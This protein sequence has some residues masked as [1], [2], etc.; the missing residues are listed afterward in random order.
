MQVA[1]RS[2][3]T[4]PR[5]IHRPWV[6]VYLSNT[7]LRWTHRANLLQNITLH[8]VVLSFDRY[9]RDDII[10]EVVSPLGQLDFTN[11]ENCISLTREINPRSLKV[12]AASVSLRREKWAA[13]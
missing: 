3:Y 13:L 5:T 9:S 10:G 4:Y 7:L 12:S 6:S 1:P 8:F 11:T 2:I